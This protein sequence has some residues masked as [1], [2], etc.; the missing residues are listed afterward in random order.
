MIAKTELSRLLLSSFLASNVQSAYLMNL[1]GLL[2]NASHSIP[3]LYGLNTSIFNLQSQQTVVG[4]ESLD[5]VF[6]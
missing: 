6:V 2:N 3:P 4:K 5:E 1:F